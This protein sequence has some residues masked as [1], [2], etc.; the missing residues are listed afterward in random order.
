MNQETIG[1]IVRKMEDE[2]TRGGLQVSKY[3]SVDPYETINTIE[4]YLNSTHTSGQFDSL[5]REKPFANISVAAANIWFRATDIDRK[6][7]R[8]KANK[9]EDVMNAL[10]ATALIQDWMTR[11]KFGQFLNEW[12]RVLSRYGS[13]IIKTIEQDGKLHI[14]VPAWNM[15]IFDPINFESNPKIEIF[16]LTESELRRNQ[17]YDQNVV[18]EL[19]ASGG[20]VRTTIKKQ[21]KGNRSGFYKVYEVHTV[22]PLSL[23]TGNESD[24]KKYVQQM[25]VFSYVRLDK[26]DE[27]RDFTL[28]SGRE[29][30]DPYMLTH[31]IKEDG[32]TLSIGAVQHLF[33][34]Q[35]MTNHTAKAI[36]D[37]LD[38]ASKIFFQTAD[39]RFLGQNATD[40]IESGEIVIHGVNMPLTQVNNAS[41]D[42][43]SLMNFGNQWKSWG[44][45]IT[46]ISEA[47]LGA[48]PKSGTAWRQTEALLQESYSLFELMTENKGLYIEQLFRERVIPFI[49][50]RLL[51][52][53]DEISAQ[54]ESFDI[55]S[56]D[57]RYIK[58]KAIK[59]SNKIIRDRVLN[60]QKTTRQEQMGMIENIQNALKKSM[61]ESGNQRFFVPSDISSSTWKDELDDMEWDL[62]VDVT[63]ESKDYQSALATLNTALQVVVNPMF[64]N[65]KR[66]QMIVDEILKTS[67]YLSPLQIAQ[68]HS[69]SPTPMAGSAPTNIQPLA[70]SGSDTGLPTNK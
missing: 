38:I 9:L 25:H 41:H 11:E 23:I 18:E 12:G 45:E 3:V 55:E 56:I 48:A 50:K 52:N 29:E 30:Y 68:V 57:S 36:K 39:P 2:Y 61:N 51:D 13:A 64:E 60:G 40:A 8:V 37:Q 27:Y 17:S 1:D 43:T 46:G 5:G 7:I 49:R 35:W 26:K 44:N 63:G 47:M 10:I 22:Q 31:L 42:V 20:A 58:N 15:F 24:A 16:E 62:E 28:Y 19:I 67:G 65:N 54:L 14:S 4:A 6:H 21:R 32:Q 69:V 33:Q 66:A 59:E 53:A 70:V 34:S